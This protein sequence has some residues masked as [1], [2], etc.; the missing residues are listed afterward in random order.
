[1]TFIPAIQP[2]LIIAILRHGTVILNSGKS[3]L[4]QHQR[5]RFSPPYELRY[6]DDQNLLLID[7]GVSA[8]NPAL[9]AIA[10]ALFTQKQKGLK[11]SDITVLSIGT[12]NTTRAYKYEDIKKWG[13]LGWAEHLP[14]MFMSPAAQN[15][16]A[17][18]YH[19]LESA[20][21]DYLRLDFDLNRQLKGD[22]QP[23][24]LRELL[25]KPYN[26]YVAEVKQKYDKVSEDIDNPDNCPQL[27]E[28]AECYLE[29]GEVYY[30]TQWISVQKAI[31]QFIESN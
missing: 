24:R 20:E 5:P 18:C 16:E 8:N 13:Q 17:I 19:I 15:S 22:P 23:G 1:M 30:K 29:G 12:G 21:R 25:D 6:N 7:G 28:A 4:L 26:K 27:I 14:D 2:G 10:H 9:L 31:E 11:L 3:A